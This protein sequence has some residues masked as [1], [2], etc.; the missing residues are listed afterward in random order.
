MFNQSH[1]I[2]E[3]NTDVLIRTFLNTKDTII[4]VIIR[5]VKKWQNLYL[6][7]QSHKISEKNTAALTVIFLNTKHTITPVIIGLVK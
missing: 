3:K 7:N 4:R 1:K 2:S 5:L 6:F